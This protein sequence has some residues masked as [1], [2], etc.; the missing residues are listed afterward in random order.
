[1]KK[2]GICLLLLFAFF[3]LSTCKKYP[4]NTL[5]FRRVKNLHPIGKYLTEFKVNGIDSMD[6]L[7]SYYVQVYSANNNNPSNIRDVEFFCDREGYRFVYL[8]SDRAYDLVDKYKTLKIYI[9]DNMSIFERAL[10]KIDYSTWDILYFDKNEKKKFKQTF[11]GK[12]YE[13]TFENTKK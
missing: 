5:W 4:E 13:I 7:N 2:T 6:L 1:M 11:N 10:F 12:T 8:T 3:I 9:N